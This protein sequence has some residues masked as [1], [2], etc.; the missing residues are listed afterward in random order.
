MSTRRKRC[1]CGSEPARRA[2]GGR[3][4]RCWMVVLESK[5]GEKGARR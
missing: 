3:G 4:V 5:R 1:G 2:W